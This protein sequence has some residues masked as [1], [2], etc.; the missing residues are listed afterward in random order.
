MPKQKGGK[1]GR[2]GKPAAKPRPA[3]PQGTKRPGPTSPQRGTNSKNRAVEP[4]GSNEG[5]GD[6]DVPAPAPAAAASELTKKC[7]GRCRKN[8]PQNAYAIKEWKKGTDRKCKDCKGRKPVRSDE[9]DVTLSATIITSK[10]EEKD[11]VPV[12]EDDKKRSVKVVHIV[13]LRRK[14][15]GSRE[16]PGEKIG[17][18]WLKWLAVQPWPQNMW[19]VVDAATGDK[20]GA[21]AMP[22]SVSVDRTHSRAT[23]ELDSLEA[24]LRK[25]KMGAVSAWVFRPEYGFIENRFLIPSLEDA[26][27]LFCQNHLDANEDVLD[28]KCRGVAKKEDK[29]LVTHAKKGRWPSVIRAKFLGASRDFIIL[30]STI[31][32]RGW[33]EGR[34]GWCFVGATIEEAQDQCLRQVSTSAWK[35]VPSI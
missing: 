8:L 12:P 34:G 16:T 2:S 29:G 6:G 26:A 28:R 5:D 10:G 21:R 30:E 15:G 1:G 14:S 25:H 18:G 22:I 17:R 24:A 33:S 3:G 19:N 11:S 31:G 32:A 9:E 23:V 13:R 7:S 27:R 4:S 35:C 20:L